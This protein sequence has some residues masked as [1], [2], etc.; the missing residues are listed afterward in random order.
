MNIIEAGVD[1]LGKLAG[2]ELAV[3]MLN[4]NSEEFD[5]GI[6]EHYTDGLE[7]YVKVKGS[8]YGYARF[9]IQSEGLELLSSSGDER[10]TFERVKTL[11]E[12]G[13]DEQT[14]QG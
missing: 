6:S 7:I 11:L 5:I 9:L 8:P 10:V 3:R 14:R 12:G 4:L 2:I 1:L 13:G